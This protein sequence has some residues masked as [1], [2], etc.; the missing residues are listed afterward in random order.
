[1]RLSPRNSNVM[2]MS[3]GWAGST[4]SEKVAGGRNPYSSGLGAPGCGENTDSWGIDVEQ[5]RAWHGKVARRQSNAVQGK[6]MKTALASWGRNTL[7][8]GDVV[9][10][11]LDLEVGLMSV[12]VNGGEFATGTQTNAPRRRSAPSCEMPPAACAAQ[13]GRK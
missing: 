9:R 10:L 11:A 8:Q 5:K 7:R 1:M 2:K 6:A 13:S 4:F 12:A 3:F